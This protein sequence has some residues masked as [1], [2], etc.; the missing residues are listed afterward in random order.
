M[1][2]PIGVTV[3]AIVLMVTGVFVLLLGLEG[4]GYTNFGLK[5]LA[6]NQGLYSSTVIISGI[7]SL[8]AAFGLFTLARWAW[9]LAIAV[10]IFRVVADGFGLVSQLISGTYGY[11]GVSLL[12]FVITVVILWYFLRPDVKAAFRV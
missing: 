9:Y 5:Q 4:A 7:L 6:P 2:R 1:S 8:I 11:G 12:N 10:L 3:V